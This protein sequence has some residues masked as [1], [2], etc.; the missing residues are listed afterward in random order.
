MATL[1]ELTDRIAVLRVYRMSLH[2][3]ALVHLDRDR[4]LAARLDAAA[5][6]AG[7][8]ADEAAEVALFQYV[9]GDER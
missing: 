6:E 3:R 2:S 4:E 9:A 7:R 5:Q 8:L 1:C